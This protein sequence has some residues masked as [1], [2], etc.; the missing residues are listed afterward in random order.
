M[1]LI[2]T[3]LIIGTGSASAHA[4]DAEK[5]RANLEGATLAKGFVC[6]VKEG[7]VGG[8]YTV[9]QA[10]EHIRCTKPEVYAAFKDLMPKV[11]PRDCQP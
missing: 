4:L 2:V 3:A 10:A 8:A 9:A 5:L 11:A 7:R 6:A 1:R